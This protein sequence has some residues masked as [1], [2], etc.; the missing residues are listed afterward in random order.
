MKK[1][2]FLFSLLM[3]LNIVLFM[4]SVWSLGGGSNIVYATK[5]PLCEHRVSCKGISILESLALQ[6]T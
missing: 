5:R 3:I 4:G 6:I 1:R 2:G